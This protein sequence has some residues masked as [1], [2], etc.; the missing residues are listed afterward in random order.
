VVTPLLDFAVRHPRPFDARLML[1]EGLTLALAT[2]LCP[3]CWVESMPLVMQFACRQH[4]LS[5]EEALLAATVNGAKA[6][7]L[8]DRGALAPGQLADIQIWDIP[9]VEDVIYRLGN[10]AVETVIKRGKIAVS[11]STFF[12]IPP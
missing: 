1:E 4:R 6:L 11:D 2:D 10:N 7:G 12:A 5:P 8:T 3:A 9:T